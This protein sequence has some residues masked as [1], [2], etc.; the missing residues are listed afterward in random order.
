MKD[1]VK[2]MNLLMITSEISDVDVKTEMMAPSEQPTLPPLEQSVQPTL[3]QSAQP[4]L[5]QSVQTLVKTTEPPIVHS[6]Q[7]L[8][9]QSGNPLQQAAQSPVVQPAYPSVSQAG[10]NP[11]MQIT[12]SSKEMKPKRGRGRPKRAATQISPNVVVPSLSEAGNV[13]MGSQT[14]TVSKSFVEAGLDHVPGS[15]AVG[16]GSGTI[17]Q[18]GGIDTSH[19]LSTPACASPSSQPTLVPCPIPVPDKRRGRKGQSGGETPLRRGRK[20]TAGSTTPVLSPSPG[21][22]NLS[23]VS[24]GD[25]VSN[26]GAASVPAGPP[27]KDVDRETSSVSPVPVLLPPKN[28]KPQDVQVSSSCILSNPS[29]PTGSIVKADEIHAGTSNPEQNVPL[30]PLPPESQAAIVGTDTTS[31]Q[32]PQLSS[33]TLVPQSVSPSQVVPKQVKGRGSKAQ[34]EGETPRRRGRKPSTASTAVPGESGGQELTSTEPPQ[35][36]SRVS[37]GKTAVASRRKQQNETQDLVN[38]ILAEASEIHTSDIVVGPG[39][40]DTTDRPC[41]SVENNQATSS[42]IAAEL[43]ARSP[44]KE[45]ANVKVSHIDVPVSGDGTLLTKAEACQSSV[46]PVGIELC[47][48]PM[49]NVGPAIKVTG[50]T[51]SSEHQ[52]PRKESL[53]LTQSAFQALGTAPPSD[54]GI[55]SVQTEESYV[56]VDEIANASL[57]ATQSDT[58]T[59]IS[60][61]QNLESIKVSAVSNMETSIAT[62]GSGDT[63]NLASSNLETDQASD[64]VN[65]ESS[66]EKK[67]GEKL[68][69]VSQ[70]DKSESPKVDVFVQDVAGADKCTEVSSGGK[71]AIEKS[72]DTKDCGVHVTKKAISYVEG[73]VVEADYAMVETKESINSYEVSA[74]FD[75]TGHDLVGSSGEDRNAEII[76]S[77]INVAADDA[78]CSAGFGAET[79]IPMKDVR[80]SDPCSLTGCAGEEPERTVEA[81]VAP[82]YNSEIYAAKGKSEAEVQYEAKDLFEPKVKTTPSIPM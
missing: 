47:K 48:S 32:N 80:M 53:P 71:D 41:R 16:N 15:T 3:A 78:D 39:L 59:D 77:A 42:T 70:V 81:A 65:G 26:L 5:L 56:K 2:E 45:F 75:R 34:S 49:K 69:E 10:Q 68:E 18:S 74:S 64:A 40:P 25:I 73:D 13:N 51:Q 82:E 61:N 63:S 7:Y 62:Q 72:V 24:Q 57:G 60:E 19:A 17:L 37:S 79:F 30:Y 31:Q 55:F 1:E 33:V 23:V 35:K 28:I 38:V 8:V 46:D 20:P 27:V 50:D 6:A 22:D 11:I 36:K 67:C 9:A 66:F 14:G 12:Q 21:T 43:A 76:A 4:S 58:L 54:V 29:V 44:S 52:S